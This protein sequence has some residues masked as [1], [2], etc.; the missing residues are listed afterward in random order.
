HG[1]DM[2]EDMNIPWMLAGPG[3]KEGHVIERDVSLLDTAPTIA[4]LFG[5]DA[6]QQWEGSAVMEAYIN[7][8]G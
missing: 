4:S 5:L 2:P 3:I 1:T 7:G 8:A 6:H